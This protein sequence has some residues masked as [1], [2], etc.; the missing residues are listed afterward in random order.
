MSQRA[1]VLG[2]SAFGL[3]DSVA[4]PEGEVRSADFFLADVLL[5]GRPFG[6]IL[7]GN[8]AQSERVHSGLPWPP[9]AQV[10]PDMRLRRAPI[11]CVWRSL[12][13]A[14]DKQARWKIGEGVSFPLGRILAAHV[15]GL[16]EPNGREQISPVVAIP[17]D[18]DE[19]GQ[20]I[21]KHELERLGFPIPPLFGAP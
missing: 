21:L 6:T 18:L 2:C 3:H 19:L 12:V 5:P 17:N 13:E 11:A 16:L 10:H 7:T 14:K 4:T 20:E 1:T 8:G 15:V 9:E